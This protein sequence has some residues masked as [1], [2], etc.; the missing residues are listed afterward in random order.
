MLSMDAPVLDL[1]PLRPAGDAWTIAYVTI[2]RPSVSESSYSPGFG[3]MKRANDR[4]GWFRARGSGVLLSL[5]PRGPRR[6]FAVSALGL[7]PA[8]LGVNARRCPA[9]MVSLS[10]C[11]AR[12]LCATDAQALV[13]SEGS[14]GADVVRRTTSV[15]LVQDTST[16]HYR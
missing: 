9:P 10:D 2:A 16:H 4:L 6:R 15:V 3:L 1:G 12:R 7:E 5:L 8:F 14:A 11:A 13:L